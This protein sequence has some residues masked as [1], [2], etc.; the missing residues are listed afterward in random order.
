MRLALAAHDDILR[1]VA[2]R[3]HGN[4]FK[5]FGDAFCCAFARP[6]DG[7][8]A[9]VEMQRALATHA[10]PEDV[11][12][13]RVR[14]GIHTGTAVERDGDYFGPTL[15]RVA[16]LMSI[17]NGEQVLVS[18]TTAALLRESPVGG[19][20]LQDLGSHRLRDLAQ[21]EPTF[22]LVAEGLR[23]QFPALASLDAIPNNLPSQI[24]SFVGRES[25]LNEL[26]CLLLE[27][28]LVTIAGLGGMGKTRLALQ[29][30]AAAIES[31]PD[32]AWFVDLSTVDDAA[33]VAQTI[34]AAVG[35]TETA[36]EPIGDTLLRELEHRH[37]LLLIDNAEH[38]LGAVASNVKA[39]LAKCAGVTV[40]VTSREPLHLTGEQNY[41]LAA[42]PEVPA[43]ATATELL[44]YD[45]T[46]LFID[47]ARANAPSVTITDADASEICGIYRKLEGIPLAIELAAARAGTLSFRQLNER[48]GERLGLLT[49]RDVTVG[50]HRTLRETIEWSY[51]LLT[52]G[53]KR[54]LTGIAVFAGGFS[55]E[56]YESVVPLE[57]A[58]GV[59]LIQ[60]LTEK[61]FLQIDAGA[62]PPRF[63]LLDVIREFVLAEFS[64]S[65]L[66]ERHA[67]YYAR[68]AG[69]RRD[70]N[71]D[72]AVQWYLQLDLEMPNVR[73]ALSWCTANDAA[74]GARV[75]LDVSPYWRVRGNITEARAR[76]SQFLK[77]PLEDSM[78]RGALLCAGSSFAAMQ[79][80]FEPAL[81]NAEEALAL[82]RIAGEPGGV[83][84]ALFRIAEIEHRRGRLDRAKKLYQ[85]AQSGFVI[86]R[87]GRGEML[88]I[89][90]L[91]MLARQEGRYEQARVLLQ[92]ALRHANEAGDRR[93][94]GDFVIALAWSHVYL[95]DLNA[96]QDLFEKAL[97]QKESERDRY[98]VCRACHGLGTVALKLGRL[99]DAFTRFKSTI[100]QALSLQLEDYQFRGFDGV[101][102]VLAL[103]G[104]MQRAGEY[105]GLADRLFAGSGRQLRDSIAHDIAVETIE[106]SVAPALKQ[107]WLSRG[108]ELR[109]E[110]AAK[111][112]DLPRQVRPI[113]RRRSRL[114]PAESDREP[115]DRFPK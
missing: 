60:S 8:A 95:E 31:F 85:E 97:A 7:I 87:N 61:S 65:Q 36:R 106:A 16:R 14:M 76:L 32:G 109:P 73:T 55:L 5:T 24:S 99:D 75:T 12:R 9:A 67:R 51:R 48:L 84:D 22:Q 72:A 89:G 18:S 91:G 39:I 70:V 34:A 62:E 115:Q 10:W 43:A 6:Q 33:L 15:N 41:R 45:G 92:D 49:S 96:A 77:L 98:G 27:H 46:R 13:I 21:A 88:C 69:S 11:G 108:A 37:V 71:G 90:N 94:I 50:R 57:A 3:H 66:D 63:R 2:K 113:E 28:R 25:E 44:H 23:T 105:L 26:R 86:S 79:D 83:A 101:S 64:T 52:A 40:L 81:A 42:L 19:T 93:I 30:A 74:L 53:E 47:R 110:E 103:G 59:D 35:I 29:V 111:T 78:L 4:V 100:G 58:S 17:G 20:A 114:D 102:A 82:Y 107:S 56:A 54:A 1:Q 38:V 112:C 68:Y 104:D 80:D